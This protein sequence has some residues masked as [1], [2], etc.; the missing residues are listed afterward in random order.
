MN[1]ITVDACDACNNEFS[2]NDEY[3]RLMFAKDAAL[4]DHPEVGKIRPAAM[5]AL[6]KPVQFKLKTAIERS[7]QR[8]V[9]YGPN[10]EIVHDSTTFMMRLER[11]SW[12]AARI[13]VG[14]HAKFYGK[15]LGPDIYVGAQMCSEIP[16][17]DASE[18][19]DLRDAAR[20]TVPIY[21]VE[22]VYAARVLHDQNDSLRTA[23][24]HTFYDRV[25]YLAMTMSAADAARYQAMH[26]ADR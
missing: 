4:V 16:W 25:E 8:I 13:T 2:Q 7:E 9:I 22:G 1:L 12:M 10:N 19:N 5:R 11:V 3:F 20:A 6:E 26:E 21:K 24:W 18:L 14:L 23:W 15:L 17:N